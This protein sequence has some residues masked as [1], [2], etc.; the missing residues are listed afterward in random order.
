MYGFGD[1]LIH[2]L[3]GYIKLQ[4]FILSFSFEVFKEA[5]LLLWPVR[6]C[7]GTLILKCIFYAV[8]CGRTT[9]TSSLLLWF[10]QI[11]QGSC[12]TRINCAKYIFGP[13]MSLCS[14]IHLSL[15]QWDV[16]SRKIRFMYLVNL[17]SFRL[18][19]C[20]HKVSWPSRLHMKEPQA[21]KQVIY[22][23]TYNILFLVLQRYHNY[24]NKLIAI[25]YR[26]VIIVLGIHNV[27]KSHKN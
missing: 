18:T 22:I 6:P 8:C 9:C 7:G 21:L 3:L 5:W 19:A 17:T 4:L 2:T 14:P 20:P 1:G 25:Y 12:T 23:V 10:G 26:N 24:L 27:L 13:A 11:V 15:P 16:G